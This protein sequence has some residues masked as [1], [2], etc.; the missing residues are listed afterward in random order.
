VRE[1]VKVKEEIKEETKKEARAEVVR[2][3]RSVQS[4]KR[5]LSL[6]GKFSRPGGLELTLRMLSAGGL[7]NSACVMDVGCGEGATV[8]ALL[9]LGYDVTGVDIDVNTN[10]DINRDVADPTFCIPPALPVKFGSAYA[11]PCRDYELDGLLCECVFSLLD[12]PADALAEFRRALEPGGILLMSDLCSHAEGGRIEGMP[13]YIRHIRP[14]T[15]IR[16]ILRDGGFIEEFFEDCS[17][18]LKSMWAQ[19][20]MDMGK[21]RMYECLGVDGEGMKQLKCGYFTLGARTEK[22]TEKR[23]AN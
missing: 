5:R 3:P 18:S 13:R 4:E 20:M 12:R 17:A 14:L 1:K 15:D 19:M 6:A 8:E 2:E 9:E 23:K 11:L 7:S 22:K 21:G 16:G 10:V